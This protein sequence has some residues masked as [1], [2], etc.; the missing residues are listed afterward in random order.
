MP[1]SSFDMEAILDVGEVVLATSI[2][3]R[4]SS[5]LV[6]SILIASVVSSRTFWYAFSLDA[7][8]WLR[9]DR[10]K[11]MRVRVR[12]MVWVMV[13]QTAGSVVMSKDAK[14]KPLSVSTWQCLVLRLDL[15]M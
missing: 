8:S 1:I 13:P 7:F 4:A 2:C 9:K 12:T 3:S 11:I 5:G 14:P 10:M 15:R 6:I